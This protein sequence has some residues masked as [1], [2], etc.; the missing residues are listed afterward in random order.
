MRLN[1]KLH[2]EFNNNKLPQASFYALFSERKNWKEKIGADQKPHTPIRYICGGPTAADNI[3]Q[4][5]HWSGSTY[6]ILGDSVLF[7]RPWTVRLAQMWEEM[8]KKSGDACVEYIMCQHHCLKTMNLCT[9]NWTVS[10]AIYCKL[11][12][13]R[14]SDIL[15]TH[16][17]S[18]PLEQQKD[19]FTTRN[20]NAFSFDEPF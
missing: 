12:C 6:N 15:G 20:R 19:F 7:F 4:P 13:I 1:I 16:W 11:V 2:W 5:I 10:S 18:A 8:H 17:Y 9:S 3:C 14:N